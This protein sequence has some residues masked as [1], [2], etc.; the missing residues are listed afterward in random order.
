MKPPG[1]HVP[2]TATERFFHN[3][4]RKAE[5]LK[6]IRKPDIEARTEAFVLCRLTPGEISNG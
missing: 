4:L 1:M 6:V 2:L 3:V 5:L